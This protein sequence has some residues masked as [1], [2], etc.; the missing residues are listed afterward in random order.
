MV[1]GVSKKAINF[2]FETLENLNAR[3]EV[4]REAS[5]KHNKKQVETILKSRTLDERGRSMSK[6]SKS[7]KGS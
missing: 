6:T 7:N 3:E 1:Y 5:R 4:E 2:I